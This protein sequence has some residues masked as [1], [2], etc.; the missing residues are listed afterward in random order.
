MQIFLFNKKNNREM[1]KKKNSHMIF[2]DLEAFGV[3]V[4]LFGESIN[5][6]MLKL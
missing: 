2:I 4:K 6:S 1:R 3:T 5:N